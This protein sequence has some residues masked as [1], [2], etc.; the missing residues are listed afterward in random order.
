MSGGKK[1]GHK[2]SAF[3]LAHVGNVK[4][5]L[6]DEISLIGSEES[7]PYID[8]RFEA[9]EAIVKYFEQE[10]E[11][12]KVAGESDQRN[13]VIEAFQDGAAFRRRETLARI[14]KLLYE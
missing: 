5:I 7:D 13:K 4:R 2:K 11:S 10:A 12:L 1:K 6:D 3:W 8:G 9:C 14:E